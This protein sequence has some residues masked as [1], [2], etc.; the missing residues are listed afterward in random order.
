MRVDRQCR[1]PCTAMALTILTLSS[2]CSAT[3]PKASDRTVDIV[4][5]SAPV[6]DAPQP[7]VAEP[8][9]ALYALTE[10]ASEGSPAGAIELRADLAA[11]VDVASLDGGEVSVERDDEGHRVLRFPA[12]SESSAPARAVVRVTPSAGEEG[13]DPLTPGERDFVFGARFTLDAES[14]G[15][16]VDGGNNLV[17]RGLASDSSQYKIDVDN[18]RASCRIQG[19]EGVAEVRGT[20]PVVPG[21]WYRATCARRGDVVEL[22]VEVVDGDAIRPLEIVTTAVRT[23]EL[24]W[25][26]AE[27][28]LSVGGKLAANGAVIKSAT[29]QFNGQIGDVVFQM[30][31]GGP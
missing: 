13:D 24:R 31:G 30:G 7:R 10:G 1:W 21:R 18:L 16:E 2:A 27:T 26:R 23:G 20:Q 15:T 17:Q 19:L 8:A 6:T 3:P 25:E 5:T 12:F 14:E 22:S 4:H 29:D 28:P 11:V 9:D